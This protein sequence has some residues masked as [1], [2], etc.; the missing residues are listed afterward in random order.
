[1][2]EMVVRADARAMGAVTA[3]RPGGARHSDRYRTRTIALSECIS[4][5]PRNGQTVDTG[6]VFTPVRST[7][8]RR[9][10][11]S[12]ANGNKTKQDAISAL[13]MSLPTIHEGE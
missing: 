6:T 8:A 5:N 9:Y 10:A 11:R 7:Q 4:Y 3:S 13:L 12:V 2:D 1:M